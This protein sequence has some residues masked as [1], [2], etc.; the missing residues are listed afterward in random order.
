[1][2]S[3][4]KVNAMV[5]LLFGIASLGL[6][7]Y[8][9]IACEFYEA[10]FINGNGDKVTDRPGLFNCKYYKGN[11]DSFGGPKNGFDL[12]AM[13]AGFAAAVFGFFAIIVLHSSHWKSCLKVRNIGASSCLL[14][15]ASVCQG[16]T[17]LVLLG[18]VCGED[19]SGQCKYLTNAWLSAGASGG[20]FLSS[21]FNREVVGRGG[22]NLPK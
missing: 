22:G 17:M 6:S 13:V 21:C 5:A 19:Y 20:W 18:D 16:L 15:M 14:M 9:L 11:M 10:T 12:I 8:V 4:G 2:P 7:I 3:Y 1:M